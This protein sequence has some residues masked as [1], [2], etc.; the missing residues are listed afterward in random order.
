M[1]TPL[2]LRRRLGFHLTGC[3]NEIC[4][5]VELLTV[6]KGPSP[7]AG[8]QVSSPVSFEPFLALVLVLVQ[9]ITPLS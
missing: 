3:I 6:L 1:N 5:G 9:H 2:T 4:E 7:S 8:A